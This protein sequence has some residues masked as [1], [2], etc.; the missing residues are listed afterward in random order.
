MD[1]RIRD[2]G[3][4]NQIDYI[5]DELELFQSAVNWKNYL[6]SRLRPYVNRDV[7]EV[8]AGFGANISFIHRGD[9]TRWVSVEPDGKLCEE[10]LRRQANETIPK[11]C[12]LLHGTLEALPSDESFD[13]II[14]IDVL[15]HIEDD[16]H[17]FDLAYRRLKVGGYLVVLC[18]AHGFLYSPFDRAIGHYRRYNKRMYRELSEH[19]PLKMEYLDSV[20]MLASTANKLLLRQNYPTTKQI[21][22]WDGVFV[23]LSTY[24]DTL[25][26][27][28]MGKSLLGV[29]S[30][31]AK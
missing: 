30:K 12:Q 23:R 16:M 27:R 9:L 1:D 29:W 8:G 11:Q 14:Y 17:E 19:R 21:A 4:S 18:P 25:T 6:G 13:S 2:D 20:G 10:F 22:L 24:I 7:L 26:L 3:V 15:E 5:G 28:K 31:E